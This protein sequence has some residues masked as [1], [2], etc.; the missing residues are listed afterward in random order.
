MRVVLFCG[1]IAA[2]MLRRCFAVAKEFWVFLMVARWLLV[3]TSQNKPSLY[4]ILFPRYGPS[5]HSHL[6]PRFIVRQ[7]KSSSQATR[8]ELPYV[9]VVQAVQ[10]VYIFSS[11]AWYNGKLFFLY[12]YIFIII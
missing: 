6:F 12:I 3:G 9:S 5:L 4:D 2:V 10:K 8:F 1:N 7:I 11:D